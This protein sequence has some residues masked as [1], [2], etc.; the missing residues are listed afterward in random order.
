MEPPLPPTPSLRA[1]TWSAT[2]WTVVRM[3]VGNAV[4]ILQLA[5]LSRILKRTD[6]GEA[7]LTFVVLTLVDVF[8]RTGLEEALLRE[9]GD[10]TPY[11]DATWSIHLARGFLQALVMLAIAPLISAFQASERLLGLIALTSLAPILEGTRGMGPT[12]CGRDLRLGRVALSEALVAA[13]G[14][15]AGIIL[16]LVFR[17]SW[18]IAAQ[19]VVQAGLRSVMSYAIFPHRHRWTSSWGPLRR[20]VRFGIFFNLGMAIAFLNQS[21]DRLII[22][23]M[24]GL[25]PLGLYDRSASLGTALKQQL[26]R[27]LASVVFPSFSK[28]LDHPERLGQVFRRFLLLMAMVSAAISIAA[29]A[30]A[31]PIVRILLGPGFGDAVPLFRILAFST[32]L[33]GFAIGIQNLLVIV[34][35]PQY[36]LWANLTQ[37]AVLLAALPAGYRLGGL[38]GACWGVLAADLVNLL[39]SL[40]FVLQ[41][42]L[43]P[44][45]SPSAPSPAVPDPA[46][47]KLP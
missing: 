14:L 39:A 5:I 2:R 37:L 28:L 7:S 27:F 30:L 19:F 29:W 22:G 1:R 25:G 35:R 18:A 12:L 20:F 16:A 40:A 3:V 17:S 34:G 10:V 24:A 31:V 42:K 13:L 45:V 36:Y 41:G 32:A 6:F 44:A 43:R 4:Q 8:T 26:I 15:L 38:A 11:L 33:H 9:P 47:G 23:H 21:V 46:G